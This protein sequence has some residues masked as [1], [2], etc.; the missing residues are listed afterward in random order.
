[1]V[2]VIHRQPVSEAVQTLEE[3][4]AVAGVRFV[5]LAEPDN[6][7]RARFTRGNEVG[8]DDAVVAS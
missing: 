2:V 6:P 5:G 1:M 7:L 4:P 3:Q 8:L